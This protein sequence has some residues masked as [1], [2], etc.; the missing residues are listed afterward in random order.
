MEKMDNK[1]KAKKKGGSELR[2]KRTLEILKRKS[3]SSSLSKK[4]PKLTVCPIA[5][6]GGTLGAP[7]QPVGVQVGGLQ[8]EDSVSST[9]EQMQAQGPVVSFGEGVDLGL[10]GG[11]SFEKLVDVPCG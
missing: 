2:K 4:I 1:K 7:T 10:L 11:W 9:N 3:A 5:T 6:R 8:A